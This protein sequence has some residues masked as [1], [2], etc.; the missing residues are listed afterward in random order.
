MA[1]ML[2]GLSGNKSDKN[3]VNIIKIENISQIDD[4]LIESL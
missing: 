3:I 4:S 1:L 2:Y